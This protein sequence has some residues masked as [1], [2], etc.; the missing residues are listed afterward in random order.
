MDSVDSEQA[1]QIH[2]LISVFPEGKDQIVEF[3]LFSCML[4]CIPPKTALRRDCNDKYS[5]LN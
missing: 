5:I 1:G 4:T 3:Q 2:R